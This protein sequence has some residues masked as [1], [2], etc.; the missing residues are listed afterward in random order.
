LYAYWP[1]VLTALVLKPA[2]SC[3]GCAPSQ[4]EAPLP[5]LPVQP[6]A[7]VVDHVM[8]ADPPGTMVSG[9]IAN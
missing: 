1:T 4:S 5:L 6:L 3:V 8:S 2:E 7:L 9:V